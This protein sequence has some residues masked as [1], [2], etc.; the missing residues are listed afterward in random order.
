MLKEAFAVYNSKHR[1]PRAVQRIAFWGDAKARKEGNQSVT[2]RKK[3][4][5]EADRVR[6]MAPIQLCI[7]T[8]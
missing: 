2:E 4:G 5:C 3:H 7:Q 6:Y 8:A 1:S